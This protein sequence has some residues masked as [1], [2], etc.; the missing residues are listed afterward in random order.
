MITPPENSEIP[1][2]RSSAADEL[3]E[4]GHDHDELGH[5]PQPDPYRGC[6]V[7]AA[8]LGQAASRRHPEFRGQVLHHHRHQA[9]GN[10]RPQQGVSVVSTGTDVGRNVAGINKGHRR[11]EGRSD[12][13]EHP[14][15]GQESLSGVRVEPGRFGNDHRSRGLRQGKVH[16]AY[17]F[18]V[19]SMYAVR[20]YSKG[21]RGL[22]PGRR[23]RGP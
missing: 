18:F 22:R 12:Q 10:H 1:N 21:G 16:A 19:I 20:R 13:S 11:D 9:C 17:L 23:S 15:A 7:I 14:P 4:I 3:G 8:D 6:R 5:E 2:S